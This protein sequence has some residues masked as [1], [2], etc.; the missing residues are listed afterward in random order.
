MNYKLLALDIDGTILNSN[1]ELSP[2]TRRAILKAQERGVIVVLA[3][4]RR[5]ATTLPW[6]RALGVTEPLVVHNGSVI[7]DQKMQKPIRQHGIDLVMAREILDKLTSQSINYIV[8]TGESGGERVIG[9]TWA[10]KEPENLLVRFLG[11]SAEFVDEL[12][13][14]APPIRISIIDNWQKVDPFFAELKS[15]YGDKL[16]IM[17]FGAERDTWRGIEIIC[18]NCHKGTGLAYLAERLGISASEVI[19][20]GDNINDLEMITWA[21]LGVAMENGSKELKAKAKK[22]A[23]SHDEDG[24]AF[25]IDELLLV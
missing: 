3:T 25:I 1:E 19:A 7:F 12:A 10:W 8:Y 2:G 20:I 18:P 21:G 16:N 22:I 17:L 5:L 9:P 14:H 13:V 15:S 24:V 23:P 11:E 4:G 6:A